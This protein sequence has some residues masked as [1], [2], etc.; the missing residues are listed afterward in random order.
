M[1]PTV[2]SIALSALITEG[3]KKTLTLLDPLLKNLKDKYNRYEV[4]K[5]I[6]DKISKIQYVKTIWQ[7]DKAV[8]LFDFY[9]PA[10]IIINK[11]PFAVDTYSDFK[12]NNPIVIEGNVGQGKSIFLRYLA[13]TEFTV[14]N[15]IPIFIECRKIK[16]GILLDSIDAVL[17][18][19]GFSDEPHT[20]NEL[21][22]SGKFTFYLDGFDELP[23]KYV[24]DIIHQLEFF[25]LQY[26][27]ARVIATSRPNSELQKSSSFDVFKISEITDL[28]GFILKIVDAEY[29]PFE[30]IQKIKNSSSEIISLLYSPLLITLLIFNYRV[31]QVIPTQFSDFYQ[32]LFE[33]LLARH[34]NTKA[35]YKRERKSNLNDI[36]LQDIFEAF[37]FFTAKE[38][39]L[40]FDSRELNDYFFKSISL[41]K[42]D[43][44]TSDVVED[45]L[46]ITN[47]IIQDG[48]VF[49][50]L[51]KSIQEYYSSSFIK[52]R[53]ETTAKKA[54]VFLLQNHKTWRQQLNFLSE[55]DR[56]R[57]IRYI[58]NPQMEDIFKEFLVNNIYD[59]KKVSVYDILNKEEITVIFHEQKFV[60]MQVTHRALQNNL[61]YE[62]ISMY[63]NQKFADCSAEYMETL[64]ANFINIKEY[65]DYVI[66]GNQLN[67]PQIE[68]E[69][70]K[71]LNTLI[72][73][74]ERNTAFL[75]QEQYI[76]D[77]LF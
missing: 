43:V 66:N 35:G 68:M 61:L 16:T 64:Q 32:K 75:A 1:E 34:D 63:I 56:N 31:S 2:T 10:Q 47:L 38:D 57:Y 70:L 26:S 7:Y 21:L 65:K 14:N 9:Y 25:T 54:Y 20:R 76:S 28:E 58:F 30:L 13:L 55:I 3:V 37:C 15:Q 45:I 33:I 67:C 6:V 51:H 23:S 19:Y 60:G 40:L 29:E 36:Q 74:Y 22:L 11:S 49:Q 8:S 69:I 46:K 41:L 59:F 73:I 42:L 17:N 24:P 18:S 50:F 27:S 71:H 72:E 5:N 4:E 12:S 44:E 77:E 52:H 62:Q 53:D 39:I 48:M